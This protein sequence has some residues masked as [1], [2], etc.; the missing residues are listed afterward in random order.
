MSGKN[1][2]QYQVSIKKEMGISHRD[3]FRILPRVMEG[4][5]YTADG[6]LI[7]IDEPERRLEIHLADQRERPMGPLVRLPVTDVELIFF[8]YL[9]ADRV[10][11]IKFFDINFF[12]G[13]G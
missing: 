1:G 7:V 5:N 6:Q 2:G 8:N 12:K 11:F 4:R 3:F 10:S 9:E 13:G